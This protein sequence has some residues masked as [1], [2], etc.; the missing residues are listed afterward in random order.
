M[1]SASEFGQLTVIELGSKGVNVSFSNVMLTL[2]LLQTWLDN[3]QVS[4]KGMEGAI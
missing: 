4:S 1:L 3:W 2:S